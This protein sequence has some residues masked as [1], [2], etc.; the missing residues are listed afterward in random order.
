MRPT[1][2]IP[3]LANQVNSLEAAVALHGTKL[4]MMKDHGQA[5]QPFCNA[6]QSWPSSA[7]PVLPGGSPIRSNSAKSAHPHGQTRSNLV[8]RALGEYS[9][10]SRSNLVKPVV[11]TPT[12]LFLVLQPIGNTNARPFTLTKPAGVQTNFFM[13]DPA[14]PYP[15]VHAPW[16]A[17]LL[18][19]AATAGV[20]GGF[21]DTYIVESKMKYNKCKANLKVYGLATDAGDLRVA[22]LN[23]D[24]KLPCNVEVRLDPQFCALPGTLMRLMP[25]AAGMSSK[26]G[27][28]WRNQSYDGAADGL[29]Q[30]APV[31]ETV[32]SV[33]SGK[34]KCTMTV[35]MPAASAAVL[36]I[37]K[38]RE[39]RK[40]PPPPPRPLPPKANATR[41]NATSASDFVNAAAVANST[42]GPAAAAFV[43]A[44]AAASASAANVAGSLVPLPLPPLVSG[45]GN[46]EEEA[47]AAAGAGEGG[48][49][50]G[51]TAAAAAANAQHANAAAPA[52]AAIVVPRGAAGANTSQQ[53]GANA[54]TALVAGRGAAV[55]PQPKAPAAS[56]SSK[57]A[58]SDAQPGGAPQRGGQQQA[59]KVKPLQ[60]EEGQQQA[61][62]DQEL[63]YEEYTGD[64]TLLPSGD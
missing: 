62:Q 28:S 11:Q 23:K 53:H 24:L 35:P 14:R 57:Q 26:D 9:T 56:N 12:T 48:G 32:K 27:I 54:A 15:S 34:T 60:S 13:D 1:T 39:P 6:G 25:G 36:E 46:E 19:R 43:N 38:K 41:P 10:P 49:V 47:K 45:T 58:L 44:A 30:G 5:G 7:K 16:Y 20:D 17:Y 8:I 21:S 40:P 63:D 18:F 3:E 59:E 29:L 37:P 64:G 4:N 22:I 2:C 33:P 31:D 55:I 52:A 61:G 51:P 42:E 50:K